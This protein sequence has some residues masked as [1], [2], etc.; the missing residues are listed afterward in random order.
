MEILLF[1]GAVRHRGKG[2]HTTSNGR[3]ELEFNAIHA[4][5]LDAVSGLALRMEA[6]G[7]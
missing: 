4:G 5:C 1:F 2:Q 6:R 3:S 7:L